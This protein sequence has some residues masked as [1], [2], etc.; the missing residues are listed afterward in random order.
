MKRLVIVGV[1]VWLS[2]APAIAQM[3]PPP[4]LMSPEQLSRATVGQSVQIEVRVQR[5]ERSTLYG[6][7]L[8]HSTDAVSKATGKPVVIF[9]PDGTPVIMGSAADVASG[10]VLFVYGILTGAGHVDAKRVVVVTKYVTI[11]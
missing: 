8:A 10:T 1:M 5:V 6:E 7:F 4:Q 3:G 2:G 11:Q 9:F